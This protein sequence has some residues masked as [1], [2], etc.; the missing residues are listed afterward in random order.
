MVAT[1]A[2]VCAGSVTHNAVGQPQWPRPGEAAIRHPILWF[3]EWTPLKMTMMSLIR[4]RT[5]VRVSGAS[6]HNDVALLNWEKN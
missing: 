6:S 4:Q 3:D 5:H 1:P 2:R